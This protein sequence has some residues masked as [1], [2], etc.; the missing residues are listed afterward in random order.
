MLAVENSLPSP[1]FIWK[2]KECGFTG[3]IKAMRCLECYG[4]KKNCFQR[5]ARMRMGLEDSGL[6]FL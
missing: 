4:K 3:E 5:L 2:S 6:S 1:P